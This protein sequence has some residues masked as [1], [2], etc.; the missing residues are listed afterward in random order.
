MPSRAQT[1]DDVMQPASD[2]QRR[3]RPSRMRTRGFCSM[4]RAIST[5]CRSAR[6]A[7]K[8]RRHLRAKPLQGGA[9]RDCGGAPPRA[10]AGREQQIFLDAE[11]REQA[12]F[13]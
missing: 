11:R 12:Q 9:R 8:R 1:A 3:R 10:F 13:L 2:M 7:I 4:A 5:N 6:L